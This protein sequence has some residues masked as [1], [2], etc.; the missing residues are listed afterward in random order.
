MS[1]PM[2][3]D[4]VEG[5]R[6]HV[7]PF[8]PN[9]VIGTLG[10]STLLQ[11]VP[12]PKAQENQQALKHASGTLRRH[13][14]VRGLVQRMLKST[15]KGRNVT[16][17]AGYIAS[18]VKDELGAAWS[19]PPVTLWLGGKL[20]SISEEL[21]PGTGIRTVSVAPGSPVVAIDGETQV[22][23]WHELHDSPERYGLS[24]EA[25]AGVRVPFELFW[26]IEV[27][28]ARQIFYDRN[29]EGIPVT[30]NLAMSMDQRDFG[31]HLAHRVIDN[32][33]IEHNGKTVPFGKF[34]ET[35][36]RQ[37]KNSAPEV[38]TLSALRV[39]VICTLFGRGG[40]A[41]SGSTL[42]EEEL[43]EGVTPEHA[44]RRV[45]PLLSMIISELNEHFVARTA[46]STP[47]VLAGIGIA[48]HQV[49]GWA[50]AG[51][52]L[53][54]E[55]LLD[56]LTTVRWEREARYW[57]GVAG[58][59]NAKGTLNFGGGAKDAGGRVADAIVHPD[60]EYGR[61]IRGR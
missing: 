37:L 50:T 56:L 38:V 57:H 54:D 35:R 45:V 29:V 7:T 47:A 36:S 23:A 49:T 26:G 52:H 27:Q 18:G 43:P 51:N 41:R 60:T 31:T 61:K 44:S 25:L 6:L 10:L 11:L 39:L 13:A 3:T 8:R 4:E 40:L 58:S 34:V 46:I 53:T 48:A 22:A 2:P 24:V 42:R 55:E 12:S 20:S 9:A 15:N 30:K 19:T 16:S 1:I 32:V 21:V 14:E 59:A 5:I 33:R 28:D 17:Y